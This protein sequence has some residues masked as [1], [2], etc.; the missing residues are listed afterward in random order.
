MINAYKNMVY[1]SS[2][3]EQNGQLV[4]QKPP[5]VVRVQNLENF[6]ESESLI[7]GD[8]FTAYEKYFSE[9]LKKKLLRDSS[10][11]DEASAKNLAL[12][13]SE[14]FQQT[15]LLRSWGEIL[16]LYLRQSEAEENQQGIKYQ[17]LF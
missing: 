10:V 2:F 11:S 16:P 3:C 17:P 13:A 15:S 14:T 6:I 5:Q 12:Y 4:E 9:T 8:G 7:C 1:V